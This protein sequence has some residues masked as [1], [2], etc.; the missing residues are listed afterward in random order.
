MKVIQNLGS[1]CDR[2]FVWY[3][4][5][6]NSFYTTQVWLGIT[7]SVPEVYEYSNVLWRFRGDLINEAFK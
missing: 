1:Y 7:L 2:V 5:F 6:Y 3:H 4:P